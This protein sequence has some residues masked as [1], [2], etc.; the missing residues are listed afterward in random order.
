MNKKEKIKKNGKIDE[1]KEKNK[2]HSCR[3]K[4]EKKKSIQQEKRS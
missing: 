1:K 2:N 3:N 4:T